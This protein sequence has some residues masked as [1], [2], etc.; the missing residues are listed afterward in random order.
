MKLTQKDQIE[1]YSYN[2]VD[3]CMPR[4]PQTKLY[5]VQTVCYTDIKS[6]GLSCN[7]ALAVALNY[8]HIGFCNHVVP[9]DNA[10]LSLQYERAR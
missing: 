7:I 3:G 6:Q 4:W 1:K 2:L 8:P 9:K 5:T 10:Q